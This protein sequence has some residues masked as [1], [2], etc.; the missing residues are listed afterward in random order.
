MNYIKLNLV[1]NCAVISYLFVNVVR[2]RQSQLTEH[3]QHTSDG[4]IVSYRVYS[5]ARR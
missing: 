2:L 1:I 3:E 4:F 5:K